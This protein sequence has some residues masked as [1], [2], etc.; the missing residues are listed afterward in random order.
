MLA[1]ELCGSVKD[2]VKLQFIL[3]NYLNLIG[4]NFDARLQLFLIELVWILH[5]VLQL[6]DA[7]L[8]FFRLG[9]ISELLHWICGFFYALLVTCVSTRKIE[10]QIKMIC[11]VK[12]L[13][14]LFKKF[15]F[16]EVEP[17]ILSRNVLA[18]AHIRA[19]EGVNESQVIDVYGLFLL[20]GENILRVPEVLFHGIVDDLGALLLDLLLRH[21]DQGGENP[22][23]A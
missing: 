17:L 11:Q 7:G 1:Q 12:L 15:F 10:T 3:V 13:W 9:C 8:I 19:H 21:M 23:N 18:W 6:S 22:A 4:N 5:C 14:P 2:C 20:F 16:G